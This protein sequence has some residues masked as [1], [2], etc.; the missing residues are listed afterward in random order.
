MAAIPFR[1]VLASEIP[2]AWRQARARA[3]HL[4]A[5]QRELLCAQLGLPRSAA[6]EYHV[7]IELPDVPISHRYLKWVT[8]QGSDE[9]SIPIMISAWAQWSSRQQE[10]R[11]VLRG[12]LH[13]GR[14]ALV[15]VGTWS[16]AGS[17]NVAEAT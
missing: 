8:A 7:G 16:R 15:W 9:Q 6:P 12:L 13:E 1:R 4:T 10:L 5:E 11:E 17:G 3:E 2:E 14:P